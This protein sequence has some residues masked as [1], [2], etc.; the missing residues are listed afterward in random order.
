MAYAV[1]RI[2]HRTLLYASDF[3]HE[4]NV[5]RAKHEIEELAEHPGLADEVKQAMFHDNVLRFYGR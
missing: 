5:A 4:T 3:P 2:G 1:E